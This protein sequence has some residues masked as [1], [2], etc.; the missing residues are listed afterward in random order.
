MIALGR[1]NPERGKP[2][3]QR[4]GRSLAPGHCP[5]GLV[6]ETFD[7]GGELFDRRIIAASA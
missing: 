4:F 7:K 3:R 2:R 5:P 1:A 6:G